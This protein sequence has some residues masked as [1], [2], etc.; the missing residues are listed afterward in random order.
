ML[1][2]AAS[3]DA[4]LAHEAQRQQ[5]LGAVAA[6]AASD[7]HSNGSTM[8]TC[9]LAWLLAREPLPARACIS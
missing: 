7:V 6:I 8:A 2:Q 5:A 9:G 3:I 4:G 1:E